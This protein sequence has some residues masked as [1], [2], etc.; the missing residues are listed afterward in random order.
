MEDTSEIPRIMFKTA[1]KMGFCD[2]EVFIST[3]TLKRARIDRSA[4]VHTSICEDSTVIFRGVYKGNLGVSIGNSLEKGN[5]ADMV[6][7]AWKAAIR[8]DSAWNRFPQAQDYPPSQPHSMHPL[9]IYELTELLEHSAQLVTPNVFLESLEIGYNETTK[10]VANTNSITATHRSAFCYSSAVL[11]SREKDVPPLYDHCFSKSGIAPVDDMVETLSEMV[12]VLPS[13]V[14]PSKKKVVVDPRFFS[15]I[16]PA[17]APALLGTQY[18]TGRSPLIEKIGSPVISEVL[19]I[20]DDGNTAEGLPSC[21]FDDEGTKSSATTVFSSG[22]FNSFLWNYAMGSEYSEGSTGNGIRDLST[23]EVR[24]RPT[25]FVVKKGS[26]SFEELLTESG[27]L[28][29][30]ASGVH[31][32]PETGDFLCTIRGGLTVEDGHIVGRCPDFQMKDNIYSFL[33]S[34]VESS[35]DTKAQPHL[36]SPHLLVEGITIPCM[37]D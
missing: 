18:V 30:T 28:L 22:V 19:T 17:L 14:V 1:E 23:G 11:A 29:L 31:T 36:I 20:I 15:Q 7:K 32:S 12:E 24:I 6:R 25:V 13:K 4:A 8:R 3:E 33:S 35:K 16:L 10:A 27:C 34:V 5:L 37:H 2:A 26:R 9:E 21:P